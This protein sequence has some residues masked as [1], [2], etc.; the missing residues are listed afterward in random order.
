VFSVV[1]GMDGPVKAACGCP[2]A[3]IDVNPN[4][5]D[6]ATAVACRD[7]AQQCGWRQSLHTYGTIR[8]GGGAQGAGGGGGKK[9]EPIFSQPLTSSLARQPAPVRSS[10]APTTRRDNSHSGERGVPPASYTPFPCFFKEGESKQRR[11]HQYER[12][13]CVPQ[14][15]SRIV[16]SADRRL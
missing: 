16:A 12:L 9:K 5:D 14:A 6:L 11:Q 2:E 3:K 1:R 7:G 8:I 4:I 15:P 10:R 13:R